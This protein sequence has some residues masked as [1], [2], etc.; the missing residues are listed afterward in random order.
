[1]GT[2]GVNAPVGELGYQNRTEFQVERL[3][4]Q[5]GGVNKG[6][7]TAWLSCCPGESGITACLRADHDVY[8]KGFMMPST[9]TPQQ[10]GVWFC[11]GFFTGAGWFL[12]SWLLS[13]LGG[14]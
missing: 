10:V 6:P 8:S 2:S 13:H 11:V 3:K 9:I 4:E 12:S 5:G 1:M 7:E 14:M